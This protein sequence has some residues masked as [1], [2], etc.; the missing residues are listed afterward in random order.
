MIEPP[1]AEASPVDTHPAPAKMSPAD[2]TCIAALDLG[3]RNFKAVVGRLRDEHVETTAIGKERLDLGI[4]VSCPGDMVSP[5]KLEQVRAALTRLRDACVDQ[6]ASKVLAIGTRAVRDAANGAAIVAIAESLGLTLEIVSGRRE[7]EV[8]YLAATGGAK[9]MLVCDQGSRSLELAWLTGQELETRCVPSGYVS[10]Y[11]TYFL[12]A[13]DYSSARAAYVEFLAA[14]LHDL[15]SDTRGL[16]C[17]AAKHAAAFVTG[18]EKEALSGQPLTV[19]ALRTKIAT[20]EALTHERYAA[21]LD[22]TPRA[23]KVL[24]GLVLIAYLLEQSGHAEAT[25]LEA[26]L[27]AGLIVEDFLRQR[28]VTGPV[29]I[30]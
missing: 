26:E 27:P 21:L 4:E 19:D 22:T 15:P 28:L 20:L 8:A 25:I 9:G 18:K 13:R 3:S 14:H 23:S 1:I 7:A 11:E 29:T 30:T 12:P 24:P 16:M 5:D 2:A 17:F 10:A 6:G